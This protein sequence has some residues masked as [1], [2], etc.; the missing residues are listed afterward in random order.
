[1]QKEQQGEHFVVIDDF[2]PVEA[3]ARLREY[4]DMTQHRDVDS[5]VDARIDGTALRSRGG[6]F[7]FADRVPAEGPGEALGAIKGAITAHPEIYGTPGTDWKVLSFAV[8]QYPAGTRLGWHNDAGN[9]R[10]GEF[11]LYLHE[12]WR[13]SWGGSPR[14]WCSSSRSRCC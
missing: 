2:L 5:V 6:V 12:H 1:M 14:S 13:P 9:G 8:W 3:L 4:A 10:T 11:I 7:G